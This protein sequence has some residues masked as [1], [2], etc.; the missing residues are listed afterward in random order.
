[1]PGVSWCVRI[2]PLVITDISFNDHTHTH[3]QH[4]IAIYPRVSSAHDHTTLLH[5]RDTCPPPPPLQF[6]PAPMPLGVTTN[7][8]RAPRHRAGHTR[9][10]ADKLVV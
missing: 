8:T 9:S 4:A 2:A 7:D 3:T 10:V 1:M 5:T 6:T